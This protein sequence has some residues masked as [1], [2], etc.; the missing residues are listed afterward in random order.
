MQSYTQESIFASDVYL[1]LQV[2]FLNLINIFIDL[3][4]KEEQVDL[5]STG[6]YNLNRSVWYCSDVNSSSSET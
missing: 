3:R 2:S 4:E 6:T 1:K 5:P